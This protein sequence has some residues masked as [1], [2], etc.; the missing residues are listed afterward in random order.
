MILPQSDKTLY[1]FVQTIRKPPFVAKMNH[2]TSNDAYDVDNCPE[3]PPQDYPIEWPILDIISNWNPNNT[4]LDQRP[5]IYQAICRFHY[6][7]DFHKALKYR[8][9]EVPFILRDDPAILQVVYRWNQPGYLERLLGDTL[10]ETE[11]STSNQLMYFKDHRKRNPL[12]WK[13]PMKSIQMTYRQWLEKANQSSQEDM[14]PDQPHWYF[15]V[16]AKDE[17]GLHPL[18]KEMPFFAPDNPNFYL[19]DLQDLRGINCRFGMMGNTA[20]T[21]FDASR[22]FIVILGGERRY[23]LS[24]PRNCPHLA[25]YPRSHPSARHSRLNWSNPNLTEAPEFALAKGNEVVLQAGDVLYLPTY[26]FHYIVSLDLNWQCNA[27]SGYTTEHEHLI[28]K[29]GF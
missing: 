23:I 27:R 8:L 5:S 2:T 9:A 29:C 19:V 20:I 12:G 16:N 24:H 10:M 26:W 14:G 13:P 21:H 22:N 15:R 25:L 28:R 6:P 18:Y 3:N 1:D 7:T 4:T 11:Y 17:M